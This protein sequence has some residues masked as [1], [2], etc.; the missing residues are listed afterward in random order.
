MKKVFRSHFTIL[1]LVL[2]VMVLVSGCGGFKA[3]SSP[4]KLS[5]QSVTSPI[6]VQ[7]LCGQTADPSNKVQPCYKI[8]NTGTASIDI[9]TIKVRYYYTIDTQQPQNFFIDYVSG[10][11][12]SSCAGTFV[13]LST[14]QTGADYYCELSFASGAGTIAP[15]GSIQVKT[16]FSKSDFS[17]YTQSNDYS[18]D[19]TKTA[20]TDYTKTPAYI[21]GALAWGTEP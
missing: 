13:Q 5:A 3:T 1:A 8:Y 21:N 7:Y 4:A 19:A 20:Y 18:F 14:P 10:V 16:R 11:S 12:S 15:G 2:V 6:K 9:S 17:S